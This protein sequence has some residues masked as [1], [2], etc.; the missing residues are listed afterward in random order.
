MSSS[1][2]GAKLSLPMYMPAG[3]YTE[4]GSAEADEGF[5]SPSTDLLL[6]GL[7]HAQQQ[8]STNNVF[9]TVFAILS[10]A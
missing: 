2:D 5:V 9:A 1:S 10:R 3:K 6:G 7:P 8:L 4:H